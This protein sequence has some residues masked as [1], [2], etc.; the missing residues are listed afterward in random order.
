MKNVTL[1]AEERLIER[2]RERAKRENRSL[3][4]AFR[5]WL[6]VYTGQG[7]TRITLSE[8]R[9]RWKHIKMGGPYTRDEMNERR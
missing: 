3:N 7:E 2:A 9:E 6:A 5:D 4:D 1:S 8:I